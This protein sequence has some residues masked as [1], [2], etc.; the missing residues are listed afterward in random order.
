MKQFLILSFVTL[1]SLHAPGKQ[2]EGVVQSGNVKLAGVV[3][4]DGVHFARTD[5]NGKFELELGGNAYF[6]YIVT[7]AGYT[8]PFDSGTPVFYQ[9]VNEQTKS[10]IFDL[11][12]LKYDARSYTLLAIA[13]AQT[14][15]ESHFK[16]FT[17]ETL[18]DLKEVAGSFKKEKINVAG[19]SLGD[20]AWDELNFFPKYKEAMASLDIPFYPVI[21]N[22][23]HDFHL[24]DDDESAGIYRQNFGPTYYAFI[25]GK[26]YYVVLDDIIYKGD[27]NYDEE[28]TRGQLDWLKGYLNYVPKGSRVLIAMHAPF[29]KYF[30]G[31]SKMQTGQALLDLCKDYQ[32]SFLTGHTHINS[33]FEVAP[34]VIEH[35]IG[36]VCGAWWTDHNCKDGTP[37]GYQVLE[38]KDGSLSWYYKT[39]GN[40]DRNFQLKVYDRGTFQTKPNEVVAK[41]WNWD[42]EWNVQWY[43]D[44]K[45]MG[46]MEQFSSYDPDYS[47]Y[48]QEQRDEGKPEVGD[49]KKPVKSFFYFSA[50][51]DAAAKNVK[52]VATDRF[53]KTYEQEIVLHSVDVQAHRGGTGLMPENTIPAM[54]NAVKL[55]VN[56]LEMDLNISKDKQVVVCHDPYMNSKIVT[57]PDGTAIDKTDEREYALYR[58]TYDSIATFE[59]GLRP[60]AAFPDQRKIETHIPLVSVLIDS[61]ENYTSEHGLSPVYYNIE[62]KSSPEDDYKFSPEYKE[63]TDLA[64]DVLNSKQLGDRL[65]IQS[66]DVRTL[67]YMHRKYPDVRLAYLVDGQETD[68]AANMARLDFVPEFYSP[69]FGL[70]NEE[71]MDEAHRAGTKVVP[72]TVDQE[73]VMIRMLNLKV[74]GLISNYPDR[75]LMKTRRY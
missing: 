17:S 46:D 61:V 59:T 4:T 66:F 28:L 5:Q 48:L 62:I 23:D 49:Y 14:M 54:I 64:M 18:P 74:D 67:N 50:R 31:N 38:S 52:V 43:E 69:Y 32:L 26:D 21:G 41:I 57:R 73:D 8:A 16:R 25:L 56:T 60:Y 24:S 75:L 13:D 20:I 40:P 15:N 70:V 34:G 53:S 7:P 55:G 44:G 2:V 47:R 11:L 9:P 68:F 37:C 19:I 63:F 33:N 42:P 27:K 29:M 36:A 71:L 30:D 12:P 72:W 10:Y 22:H 39:T 1:L 45:M 35:N 51:P 3:V 65:I 58:M 6:V